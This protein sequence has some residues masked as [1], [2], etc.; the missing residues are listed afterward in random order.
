LLAHD[1]RIHVIHAAAS[2]LVRELDIDATR[3]HQPQH[4][5]TPT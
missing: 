5:T 4:S 3:D 1:L 2:E